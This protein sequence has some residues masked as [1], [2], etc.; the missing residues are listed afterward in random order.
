MSSA[1]SVVRAGAAMSA[2][3]GAGVG[4]EAGSG[5]DFPVTLTNFHGPFDL[6]LS[7]IG[8]H[9]L[10]VTEVALAK[11]TDDFIAY[12]RAF[13]P[14]LDLETAS[15]F[16]VVAAT[17]LDLKAARLLPSGE[18]EDAED[19]ALLEAR[20]L[21]FARLLQYRAYKRVAALIAERIASEERRHVRVATLE[22]RFAQ[23]LPE[24]LLGLGPHEFAALA[25]RA[26][27][28]R[29]AP[30][31]VGVT[32][33][34]A[35]RVSIPEQAA[36]LAT[37]LRLLGQ[38]TFGELVADCATTTLVVGRFLALL[39]LFREGAVAFDQADAL[40]EL[41]VRWIGGDE[42]HVDV[43]DEYDAVRPEDSVG[44]GGAARV[45]GVRGERHVRPELPTES[46]GTAG[47]PAADVIDI[48]RRRRDPTADGEEA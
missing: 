37:R 29:P 2:P 40:G 28:P 17:L 1:S 3:S 18:V 14:E 31:E 30:P 41:H 23:L 45:D 43:R 21:L 4:A 12:L 8:R 38:S 10:D 36:I 15:Q 16:L 13:G 33:L 24:V 35:L 19:I 44:S 6:L 7:L 47:R 39:E 25:A 46:D 48:R 26:L 9:K 20:D 34:H 42:E 22:G 32:H 11:V 5:F 27:A